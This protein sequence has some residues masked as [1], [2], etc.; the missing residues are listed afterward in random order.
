MTAQAN[1]EVITTCL[2]QLNRF[3]D[4][5]LKLSTA[6]AQ[7]DDEVFSLGSVLQNHVTKGLEAAKESHIKPSINCDDKLQLKAPKRL[8][9]EIIGELLH[10]SLT[11]GAKGQR[12]LV[13]G[14]DVYLKEQHLLLRVYD[15]G[16]GASAEDRPHLLDPFYTTNHHKGS[17][18]LGLTIVQHQVFTLLGGKIAL[19]EDDLEDPGGLCWI[20]ELP[21]TLVLDA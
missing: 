7:D 17:A 16:A 5:L 18:G 14:I 9:E 21:K 2:T 13:F 6:Q 19:H 12:D 1:G 15:T 4:R 10:N 20:I 3:L 11:H 8:I